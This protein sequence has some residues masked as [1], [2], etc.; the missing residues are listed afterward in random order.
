MT[1]LPIER[2]PSLDEALATPRAA[3]LLCAALVAAM[4][5]PALIWPIPRG[6]DIVDHEA[7]LTLYH[8]APGDR[9]GCSRSSA[10]TSHMLKAPWAAANRDWRR[11]FTYLIDAHA[12]CAPTVDAPGLTR[13][14]GAAGLDVYRID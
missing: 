1:S 9:S 5:A 11:H 2:A 4:A 13:I 14:G 10:T 7:R 12:G 8:I 3:A 6:G